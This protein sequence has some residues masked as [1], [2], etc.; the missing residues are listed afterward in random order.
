MKKKKSVSVGKGGW[1]KVKCERDLWIPFCDQ[2]LLFPLLSSSFFFLFF[3]RL[4]DG[5]FSITRP[6]VSEEFDGKLSRV[7]KDWKRLVF[8]WRRASELVYRVFFLSFFFFLAIV[9]NLNTF[10]VSSKMESR[11]NWFSVEEGLHYVTR[12]GWTFFYDQLTLFCNR[13]VRLYK[14]VD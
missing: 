8:G 2:F 5:S 1:S 3:S 10:E 7:G 6:V 9:D 4:V 12:F 11:K 13:F 14:I